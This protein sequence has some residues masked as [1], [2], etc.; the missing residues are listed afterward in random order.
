[1]PSP[2]REPAGTA[3]PPNLAGIEARIDEIRDRL[4]ALTSGSPSSVSP[5]MLAGANVDSL[6]TLYASLPDEK[7]RRPGIDPS[8]PAFGRSIASWLSTY[9]APKSVSAADSGLNLEYE[10]DDHR[11][12]I[13]QCIQGMVISVTTTKPT[14]LRRLESMEYSLR[15]ITDALASTNADGDRAHLLEQKDELERAIEAMKMAE[16]AKK[17]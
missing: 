8:S 6:E 3:A 11:A 4:A 16:R 10:L 14:A 12:I 7:E 15:S 17:Q 1:M 13:V 2:A 5:R 9:G